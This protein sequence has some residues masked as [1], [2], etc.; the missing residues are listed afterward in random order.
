MEVRNRLFWLVLLSFLY[1]KMLRGTC[2]IDPKALASCL[3]TPGGRGNHLFQQAFIKGHQTFSI[4]CRMDTVWLWTH[5][6][7]VS[8]GKVEIPEYT[9]G[10]TDCLTARDLLI[11]SKF[12]LSSSC[13]TNKN[14]SL[15]NKIIAVTRDFTVCLIC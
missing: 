1:S 4:K 6:L 8:L 10:R 2:F 12:Y 11:P 9:I 5:C 13:S 3:L 15:A 7:Q 14:R